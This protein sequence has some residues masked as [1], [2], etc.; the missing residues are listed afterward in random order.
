[1]ADQASSSANQGGEPRYDNIARVRTLVWSLKEAVQNLVKISAAYINHN[2]AV[3][4]GLKAPE[5][6]ALPPFDKAFEDFHSLLNQI[7]LHFKTIQ[8]CA[9]Q[10][11]QSQKYLPPPDKYKGA[12]QNIETGEHDNMTYG[13]YINL[14]KGQ[15]SYV[16]SL[17]KI[18][19][20]GAKR[21][22]LQQSQ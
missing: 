6:K 18:I 20:D 5:D 21:I 1:M 9:I 19:L 4:S 13:Q 15:I 2:A 16:E 3:D 11:R 14:I 22:E 8:E 7:E 12:P 10:Q 17:Q